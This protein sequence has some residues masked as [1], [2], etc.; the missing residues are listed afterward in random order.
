MHARENSL[1][2]EHTKQILAEGKPCD[3]QITQESFNLIMV[4]TYELSSKLRLV[5]SKRVPNGF[6]QRFQLPNLLPLFSFFYPLKLIC[7]RSIANVNG[8]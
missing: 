4:Q 3:A 5:V 8:V 7:K 6:P 1:H 2:L